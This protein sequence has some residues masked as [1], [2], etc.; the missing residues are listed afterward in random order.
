M[1][2][3]WEYLK[4]EDCVKLIRYQFDHYP[5]CRLCPPH[6]DAATI[7]TFIESLDEIDHIIRQGP[8]SRR[9]DI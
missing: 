7:N 3:L 6:E 9:G 4:P 2:P 8:Q 1:P 5:D